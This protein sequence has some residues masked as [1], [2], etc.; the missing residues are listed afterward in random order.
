MSDTPV[1][2]ISERLTCETCD[3]TGD[4]ASRWDQNEVTFSD[5]WSAL[6]GPQRAFLRHKAR[7]EQRSLSGVAKE[8]GAG[9]SG[10]GHQG[11]T[12]QFTDEEMR[13]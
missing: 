4:P 12:G 2:P 8:W 7:W 1:T 5:Y 6:S 11:I 9:C 3:G 13:P 10:C